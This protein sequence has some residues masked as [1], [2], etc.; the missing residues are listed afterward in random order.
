[1][2]RFFHQRIITPFADLL[3]QLC[4]IVATMVL[5]FLFVPEP[6]EQKLEQTEEQ[7]YQTAVRDA[8]TI[9]EGEVL[10]LVSITLP[11][12]VWTVTDRE[13]SAWYAKHQDGVEDWTLRTSTDRI[14][15]APWRKSDGGIYRTHR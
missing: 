14:F 7:L 13:M 8:I 4:G 9:E 5:C 3:L 12:E 15:G 2:K 6:G 11:G 10:P 1:M